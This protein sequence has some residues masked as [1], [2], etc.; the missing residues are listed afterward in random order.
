MQATAVSPSADFSVF[1]KAHAVI[2]GGSITGLLAA[3]VL[4]DH[5]KQVTVI[6][7]DTYPVDPKPRSGVPQA[8]FLHVLLH[9]GQLI[10]EDMFPG[11]TDELVSHGAP[12]SM[13][14]R[15]SDFLANMGQRR[16]ALALIPFAPFHPPEGCW[17]GPFGGVYCNA[18]MFVS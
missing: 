10:L 11:L 13:M 4:A 7:R 17:I 8:R 9:R 1:S 5:F 2:I 16:K 6:E 3:R 12:F 15:I 18:L 14:L